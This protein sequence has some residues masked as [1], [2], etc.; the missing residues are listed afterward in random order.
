MK[1]LIG[2]ILP[3]AVRMGAAKRQLFARCCSKADEG[4]SSAGT[5][6]FGGG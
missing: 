4:R 5:Q 6:A 1:A 2:R 3:K